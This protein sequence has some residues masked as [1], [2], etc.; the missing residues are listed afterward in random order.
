M[1]HHFSVGDMPSAPF[2]F[3]FGD[4]QAHHYFSVVD[5]RRVRMLADRRFLVLTENSVLAFDA[6][7]SHAACLRTG[8]WCRYAF[9]YGVLN[10]AFGACAKAPLE[11]SAEAGKKEWP[12]GI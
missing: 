5:G 7:S 10:I 6:S 2:F 4:G 3:S 12:A 11:I 9:R 1:S 8:M